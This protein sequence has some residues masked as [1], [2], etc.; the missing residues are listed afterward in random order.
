MALGVFFLHGSEDSRS[1]EECFNI[2]LIYNAK[3]RASIWCANFDIVKG[4]S[5]NKCGDG[6][7]MSRWKIR[8]TRRWRKCFRGRKRQG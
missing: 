3:E 7:E 6:N 2:M 4:T 5:E 8:K 1:G